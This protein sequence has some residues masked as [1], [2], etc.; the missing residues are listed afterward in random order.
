MSG[1][2]SS[3]ALLACFVVGLV[4]TTLARAKPAKEI[5]LLSI[6]WQKKYLT[7]SGD[8]LPGKEM[9]VLY[10]EAP[11]QR[12]ARATFGRTCGGPQ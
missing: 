2:S 6:T 11:K 12:T 1:K 5:P 8:H 9:K 7:I 4:A 10:L 3:V